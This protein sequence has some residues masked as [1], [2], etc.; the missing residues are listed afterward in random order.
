M[1]KQLML[2]FFVSKN[3]VLNIDFLPYFAIILLI[4]IIMVFLK[5]ITGRIGASIV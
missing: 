2:L 4:G 1:Q 3:E 5:D